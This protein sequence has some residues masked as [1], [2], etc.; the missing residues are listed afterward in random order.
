LVHGDRAM[1]DKPTSDWR[2]DWNLFVDELQMFL[3][4]NEA[5]GDLSRHFGEQAVEWEGVLVEK[6]IT[7]AWSGI[8]LSMPR[9]EV[10]FVDGRRAVLEHIG[11]PPKESAISEWE[12]LSEGA[13]VRFSA[14]VGAGGGPFNSVDIHNLTSGRTI[15]MLCLRE[16]APVEIAD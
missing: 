13:K 8:S 15:I 14:V 4:T 9:R 5:P 11:F 6:Q 12:N 16:G 10:E 1:D 2:R 3:R 7:D